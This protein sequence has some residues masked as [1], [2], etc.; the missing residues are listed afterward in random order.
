MGMRMDDAER[1]RRNEATA[2]EDRKGRL[3]AISKWCREA[4]AEAAP[5]PDRYGFEGEDGEARLA[6]FA[7][8]P[9][10]RRIYECALEDAQWLVDFDCRAARARIL[11]EAAESGDWDKKV[12]AHS[13]GTELADAADTIDAPPEETTPLQ[14]LFG[15][16][17]EN[18]LRL[19]RAARGLGSELA[20]ALK[21]LA[22]L[23]DVG[24]LDREDGTDGSAGKR[25]LEEIRWK[26]QKTLSSHWGL[27]RG[28]LDDLA[29]NRRGASPVGERAGRLEHWTVDRICAVLLPGRLLD[30]VSPFALWSLSRRLADFFP[31]VPD[32]VWG[33]DSPVSASAKLA[34]Y[35]RSKVRFEHPWHVSGFGDYVLWYLERRELE[36]ARTERSRFAGHLAVLRRRRRILL[37]GAPKTGKSALAMQLAAEI[38][39]EGNG[40][41]IRRVAAGDPR[42]TGLEELRV[43][44]EAEPGRNFALVVDD[45]DPARASETFGEPLPPNLH[46]ICAAKAEVPGAPASAVGLSGKFPVAM[47]RPEPDFLLEKGDARELFRAVENYVRESVP[48]E[49]RDAGLEEL[50]M[51]GHGFFAVRDDAEL[52]ENW[53]YGLLPL[54]VDWH[55]AGLLSRSPLLFR[56]RER[57]KLD[58]IGELMKIAAGQEGELDLPLG[59]SYVEL[60]PGT[61]EPRERLVPLPLV[62]EDYRWFMNEW[63]RR[64]VGCSFNKDDRLPV[65]MQEDGWFPP[66]RHWA[67]I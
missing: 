25:R 63:S 47:L 33:S 8:K 38:A 40:D 67:G 59:D 45:L 35:F 42:G 54:L 14:L 56:F 44:A 13:G 17:D 58:E 34:D 31:G 18:F 48:E 12:F 11:L 57:T 41:G 37:R 39:G 23:Q 66:D 46:V 52:A 30:A 5:N 61:R 19:V 50:P 49:L 43:R 4:Y 15:D 29:G 27:N 9:D 1:R 62:E 16:V 36:A 3:A 24:T 2:A 6:S 20:P 51:P 60:P 21:E 55:R 65:C 32:I 10:L 64:G 53:R 26:I 28:T 7:E 22:A